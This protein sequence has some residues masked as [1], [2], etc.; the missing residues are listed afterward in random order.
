MGDDGVIESRRGLKAQLIEYLRFSVA[1]VVVVGTDYL[2]YSLETDVLEMR[3]G[4]AKA[5]SFSISG[6]IGFFINR[7]WTF[8]RSG[9]S[10]GGSMV[11]YWIVYLVGLGANVS[12]NEGMLAIS[13]GARLLAF[14]VASALSGVLIY[15]GQRIWVFRVSRSSSSSAS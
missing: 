5:I 11:R 1:G 3:T 6:L 4:L 14:A 8:R 12:I 10:V 9:T 7:Y 2:L 13:D 15:F